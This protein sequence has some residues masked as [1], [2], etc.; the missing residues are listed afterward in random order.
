MAVHIPPPPSEY[1][2]IVYTKGDGGERTLTFTVV[3]KDVTESIRTMVVLPRR[4][5]CMT[6]MFDPRPNSDD[7]TVVIESIKHDTNCAAEGLPRKYGTRAMILGTLN[8]LRDL[9]RERYPHLREIELADEASYPC[10][11]FAVEE[12]GKIK[13]FATDLLLSGATYYE[14]HLN[15]KPCK[16]I[17]LQ[18]VNSVKRRV[19]RPVDMTFDTFWNRLTGVE[20][21][22]TERTADQL[23]WLSDKKDSVRRAFERHGST[24][25]RAFFQKVHKKHGCVFFSCCWWRLCIVF[26]MKRLL[27][28]A[29]VVSFGNLPHQHYTT[30]DD[31]HVGG[32]SRPNNKSKRIA[33][34][35]Q[36]E[37][38]EVFSRKIR[39]R[40]LGYAS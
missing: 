10:P 40:R 31:I 5:G 33:R 6:L 17:V 22:D 18:N 13:T 24:S 25:W 21:I 29:W 19:A 32:A 28:A 20:E 34:K 38:N 15:V 8:F 30:D 11:P 14:R 1:N 36:K 12:D 9:A 23:R 27:G 35:V 26:D 7:R 2:F 39:G 3:E 37:I 4:S 16:K